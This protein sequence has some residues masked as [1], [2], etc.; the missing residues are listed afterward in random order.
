MKDACD[1]HLSLRVHESYPGGTTYESTWQ[2]DSRRLALV[3][4]ARTHPGLFQ[5][6]PLKVMA[7]TTS[8]R[9]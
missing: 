9:G 1:A 8:S 5:S 3:D 6:G 4:E 2:V 7:E